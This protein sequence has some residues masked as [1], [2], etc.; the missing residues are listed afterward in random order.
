MYQGKEVCQ[1]CSKPGSEA[2]RYSK[3][4]LC[5]ECKESIKLGRAKEVELNEEYAEVTSWPGSLPSIDFNDRTL[6]SLLGGLL[7]G[8]H[9]PY[10]QSTSRLSHPFNSLN[11][12]G[13]E[14]HI[15]PIDLFM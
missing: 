14:R 12:H 13:S 5:K 3:D 15:I 4:E 10:A 7:K 6:S 2:Q 1:G 8:L 11:I 9:N